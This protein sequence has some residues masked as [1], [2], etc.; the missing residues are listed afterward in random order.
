MTNSE[1]LA[2]NEAVLGNDYGTDKAREFLNKLGA[3]PY[4]GSPESFAKVVAAEIAKWG[5]IVRAAGIQPE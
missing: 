1:F 2:R 4:P 5:P 3:E